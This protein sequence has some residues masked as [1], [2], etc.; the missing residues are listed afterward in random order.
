M[1]RLTL[2]LLLLLCC[3]CGYQVP[4]QGDALP[5]DVQVLYLPLFVNETTKPRL[6][7]ALT[8]AVAEA[9]GRL[10]GVRISA[11]KDTSDA[12]LE[13]RVL[14][15][16]TSAIAYDQADK[17]REYQ[18]RLS[19]E[20]KLRRVEDGRLLWQ[21]RLERKE[22]FLAN[23]DKTAQND[24]E[25]LAIAEINRRMADDLLFRLLADF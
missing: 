18:S 9:L 16:A 20:V 4:G 1:I 13:G 8:D 23:I 22:P 19:T 14:S 5:G 11:D 6:E 21:G 7:N 24:L 2:A 12:V 25:E 17:I 3:G 15:Y 10:P